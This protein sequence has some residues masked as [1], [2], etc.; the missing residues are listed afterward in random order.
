MAVD[1]THLIFEHLRHIRRGV[2]EV[3]LDVSDLKTR[4]NSV[5]GPIRRLPSQMGDL[6]TQI[7]VQSG[8]MDRIEDR[9][10]RIER[11]LELVDA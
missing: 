2:D 4:L 6:Q 1:V 7:A 10:S 8:R 5:E 9:L 3:C 11:R